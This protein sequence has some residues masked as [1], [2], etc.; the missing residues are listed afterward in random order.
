M[1]IELTPKNLLA[2]P[3]DVGNLPEELLE[4]ILTTKSFR[5]ER[6][7]SHGHACEPGFWYDQNQ[8]EWILLLSG[9]A[10]LRFEDDQAPIELK[11]GDYI[12]IA[13]HRRHRVEW[14]AAEQNTV[15]LAI[16]FD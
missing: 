3:E 13:S 12:H 4:D 6:I 1:D 16:H 8:N 5:I 7:V 14:T 2:I 10:R 11:P 15:W 9:Q